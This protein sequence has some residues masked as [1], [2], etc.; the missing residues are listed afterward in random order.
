MNIKKLIID[1]LVV[2]GLL[3]ML[4]VLA[5]QQPASAGAV[6]EWKYH[7]SVPLTNPGI[8]VPCA[9]GGVGEFVAWYGNMNF[10][11]Y[12][13]IDPTGTYHTTFHQSPQGAYGIGQTSNQIYRVAGADAGHENYTGEIGGSPDRQYTFK[14]VANVHVIGPGKGNNLIWKIRFRIT[15]NAIG[16]M[17]VYEDSQEVVCK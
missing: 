14:D 8:F 2:A 13:T 11:F 9:L 5:D 10:V 7:E 17:T 6:K 12:I 4:V 15:I 1:V 16:V 3:C